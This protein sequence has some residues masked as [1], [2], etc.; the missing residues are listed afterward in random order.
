ML[1]LGGLFSYKVQTAAQSMQFPQYDIYR[2]CTALTFFLI[3]LLV[4]WRKIFSIFTKGYRF[5]PILFIVSM[6]F[7]I[8]PMIPYVTLVNIVGLG[9]PNTLKGIFA[10]TLISSY[11]RSALSMLGG[12]FLVRSFYKED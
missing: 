3:G 2:A 4:E 5:N 10:I 11:T 12:I 8:Y 7:A 1:N 6:I 9:S